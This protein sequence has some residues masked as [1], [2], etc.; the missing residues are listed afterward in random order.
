MLDN[1]EYR[2]TKLLTQ[3]TRSKIL[4][5]EDIRLLLKQGY[6]KENNKDEPCELC[7][8]RLTNQFSAYVIT[9]KGRKLLM[10]EI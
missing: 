7:G 10:G 2:C 5:E 6:L 8:K 3:Y 1:C 4:I 9:K